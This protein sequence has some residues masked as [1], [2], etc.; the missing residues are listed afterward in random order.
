MTTTIFNEDKT[1]IMTGD[2]LLHTA[3]VQLP[4]ANAAMAYQNSQIGKELGPYN[5]RT[6]SCVDH[7]ANVLRAGGADVPQGPLKQAKYLSQ[8]GF[9]MKVK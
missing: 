2:P 5:E 7:V 8:H 4:D 1:P 9:K 6:N 3:E